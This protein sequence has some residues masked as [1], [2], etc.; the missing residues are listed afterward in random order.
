MT[1]QVPR[2]RG[3]PAGHTRYG[4]PTVPMRVP[5]SAKADVVHFLDSR[6]QHLQ[7]GTP[8]PL[9]PFLAGLLPMVTQASQ[10]PAPF[11]LP[12]LLTRVPAGFPSPADDYLE[13]GCDLNQWLVRNRHATYFMTVSGDSVNQ[14]NIV[15]GDRVIVDCSMA[16]EARHGDLVI[17]II[18]GEG[19]TI[20]VLHK[21]DTEVA[22]VPRST[23]PIHKCRVITEFDEWMIWGVVTSVVRQLRT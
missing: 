5:A 1:D 21:T 9:T 18:N 11:A 20:K 19:H 12:T 16:S 6:R 3:R 15:D 17:A 13:E 10:N 22:L 2:P 14:L 4:E 8:R 7:R 23:N